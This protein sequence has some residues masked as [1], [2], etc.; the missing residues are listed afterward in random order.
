MEFFYKFFS[1]LKK[2]TYCLRNVA[3]SLA[4]LFAAYNAVNA[5]VS[6]YSFSQTAGTYMPITTGTVLGTATGNTATTNLNS[7]IYPV[8]LPFGFNFNGTSYTSLYVSTNG[9]ISFGPAAPAPTSVSPISSQVIANGVISFGVK[10]LVVFSTLMVL[11][12]AQVGM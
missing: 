10:I 3:T 7:E 8:A 9:F 11:Q 2:I 4:F 12:V 1:I 6:S 5:Q